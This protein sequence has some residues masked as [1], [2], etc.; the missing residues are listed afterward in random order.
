MVKVLI[1]MQQIALCTPCIAIINRGHLMY[2][3]VDHAEPTKIQ[4]E[5]VQ[6]VFEGPQASSGENTNLD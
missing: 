3:R 5:Q 1:I 6:R 4:A 2:I